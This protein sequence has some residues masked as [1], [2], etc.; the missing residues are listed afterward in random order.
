VKIW[1]ADRLGPEAVQVLAEAGHEVIER[2]GLSGDELGKALAGT[3]A[4]LVRGATKVTREVLA[5]ANGLRAVARAGS[6]VDNIDLPACREKGVAVFN[7]PGANAVSVA[8]HTW[9]LLLALFRRI[10]EAA[11]SMAQGR[12]EKA[13][14]GGREVRGKTLGV[15]GFGRIGQE[16]GRIG[17]AFGCKVLAH[18]P[19]I[20]VE[21]AVV[22]VSASGLDD[23]LAQ[24]DIVSL[25]A[26]LVP[27]TRGLLSAERLAK[28]KP[29][30]VLL[31]CARGDLVD[32]G[33]LEQALAGGRLA[34]AGLDV[35]M[36]EP[37]GD[38]PLFRLPNVVATPHV[39]ASTPEAQKRAGV[40]AATAI[41]DFLATG[42]APGRVA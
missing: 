25:H 21:D 11:S 30:A 38:K 20:D 39:A 16:V 2:S 10:P 35:F 5:S 26:P 12:W 18:D 9:A 13:T 36:V 14:L 15:V 28:L 8:E 34:G 37:P 7:A 4:L 29:T 6:G 33:A 32:E 31:N 42:L 24:S 27:Q 22:G 41:R 17:L 3:D 1:I 19:L 40:E 23:L